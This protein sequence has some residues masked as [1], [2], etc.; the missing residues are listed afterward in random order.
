MVETI[1]ENDIRQAIALLQKDG[2]WPEFDIETIRIEIPEESSHGDFSSNVAMQLSGV[3]KMSP[4]EIANELKERLGQEYRQVQIVHPGF[5]NFFVTGTQL[6]GSVQEIIDAGGSYGS[7]DA[8]SGK[9][10]IIE[11]ISANPTGPLTLPNGRGGYLGDVLS[12]IHEQLGYAV[13]REYYIN[14]RGNQ[15]D[16]L[17]ESVARRFLQKAGINVPYSDELYQGDYIGELADKLDLRDYKL[18]DL[19]K[20]QWVKDRIKDKALKL[21]LANIQKVV[22]KKMRIHYDSWFSEKELYKSGLVDIAVDDIQ[23]KG[24]AYEKDGA[25][26]LKTT[27]FGDDKDRVLIKSSGEGAYIQGDVALFYERAFIRKVDKVV[28]VVGADHHGYEKRLKA[29][30]QLFESDT[31]FDIIFTQMATL[32]KDGKEVRMSKRT[33]TFVTIEELIDEVG[34]DA[35]RFFFLMY[36]SDRA[37]NFD[38]NLA[39]EQ[40]DKNPVYYVQYA[41]A[42]ICRIIEEVKKLGGPEDGAPLTLEI[43]HEAENA[44][45]K[46][47]GRLPKLLENTAESYEVHHLPTYAMD[48]ARAFHH[49]YGQC[50]VID[51]GVVNPSRFELIQAAQIVLQKTLSLL[52]VSAPEKM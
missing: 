34:N 19:K 31:E 27:S 17:G 47:L 52:G 20:V 42:R 51:E 24:Y 23:R 43:E 8:G 16:V 45:A 33:G 29:L 48:V 4:L 15:I 37:M 9:K 14:D 10:I 26:W 35:A 38:L 50:R 36:S 44:L 25:T 5:M 21:M 2:A 30:P 12:N 1:I 41:H 7:S 13:T 22:E 28:L 32:L 11:Y 39:M 18:T 3:L 49:F 46:T 6:A 40:S